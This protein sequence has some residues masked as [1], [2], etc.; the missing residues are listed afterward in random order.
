M[1]MLPT[2]YQQAETRYRLRI[3]ITTTPGMCVPIVPSFHK[4]MLYI[5]VNKLNNMLNTLINNKSYIRQYVPAIGWLNIYLLFNRMLIFCYKYHECYGNR[6]A[7]S[8]SYS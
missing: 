6:Y 7:R 8:T 3:K 2:S 4:T 1:S 5:I